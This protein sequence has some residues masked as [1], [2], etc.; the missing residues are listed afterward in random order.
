MCPEP[1]GCASMKSARIWNRAEMAR[2]SCMGGTL[3]K[4]RRVFAGFDEF[5]DRGDNVLLV[6]R[7]SD[8]EPVAGGVQHGAI[9]LARTDQGVGDRGDVVFGFLHFAEGG[10]EV[11]E[12]LFQMLVEAV[13]EGPEIHG[14]RSDLANFLAGAVGGITA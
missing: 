5:G 8:A 13:A 3:G 11:G 4:I 7:I 6:V 14:N 9:R 10:E 1:N 2:R 12:I